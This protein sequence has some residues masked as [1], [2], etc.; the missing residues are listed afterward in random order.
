MNT[1]VVHDNVYKSFLAE[2]AELDK[3]WRLPRLVV[4]NLA[5]ILLAVLL[6]T[7]VLAGKSLPTLVWLPA[8]FVELGVFIAFVVHE[9]RLNQQYRHVSNNYLQVL[10]QDAIA[11]FPGEIVEVY[12]RTK[13]RIVTDK[14]T[15]Q[16]GLKILAET[17]GKIGWSVT[18]A[19]AP[20]GSFAGVNSWVRAQRERP[21]G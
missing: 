15:Y 17:K 6:L 5:V 21:L 11:M 10:V 14:A 7:V 1:E 13:L 16:C 20:Q 3:K 2:I 9:A 19:V 4:A 18:L 8:L 12:E